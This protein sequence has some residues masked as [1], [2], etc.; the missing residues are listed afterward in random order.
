MSHVPEPHEMRTF[1][2]CKLDF[3]ERETHRAIYDLHRDLLRL[4]RAIP[5][6]GVARRNID[7]AVLGASAFVLRYFSEDGQDWLLVFNLGRELHLDPCPEPLLAP[8]IRKRWKIAWSSEDPRYGGGG[9]APLDTED[10]WRI[11]GEA[12]VVL[13]PAPVEEVQ[14]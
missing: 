4:R 6:G 7:G 11:P 8:P 5:A 2:R 13:K 10:N 1:E 12:A 3:A 9:T 14:A